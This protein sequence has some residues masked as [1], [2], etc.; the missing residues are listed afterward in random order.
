[1]RTGIAATTKCALLRSVCLRLPAGVTK[2]ARKGRFVTR[3]WVFA[4]SVP[5]IGTAPTDLCASTMFA[6]WRILPVSPTKIAPKI[7]I[8]T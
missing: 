3:T 6:N 5:E 2:I 7:S 4:L 1:M 8:A